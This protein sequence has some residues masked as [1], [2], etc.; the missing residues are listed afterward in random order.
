MFYDMF[1]IAETNTYAVQHMASVFLLGMSKDTLESYPHQ[2]ADNE[3]HRMKSMNR[4]PQLVH[5]MALQALIKSH[6]R[7]HAKICKRVLRVIG[8]TG[9]RRKMMIFP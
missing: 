8:A 6:S 4:F 9:T 7:T 2:I 1:T 5:C 3:L